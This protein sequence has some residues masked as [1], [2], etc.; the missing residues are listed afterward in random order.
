MS[1]K[2]QILIVEDSEITLYKLKAIL[3]R[4]GYSVIAHDRPESALEWITT[5]QTN[6]DLIISD[7]VMP[8]MDGYAF[9]K[10]IRSN[11]KTAK[12]PVIML[13]ARELRR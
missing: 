9:V 1:E 4:L 6:P 11:P 8:E 10:K 3:V 12:V 13:R 5:S 7:V 2:T